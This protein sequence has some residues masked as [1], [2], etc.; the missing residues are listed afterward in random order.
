[1]NGRKERR[2]RRTNI[3]SKINASDSWGMGINGMRTRRRRKKLVKYH[4]KTFGTLIIITN[5]KENFSK[6]FLLLLNKKSKMLLLCPLSHG[7]SFLPSF[8]V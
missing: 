7:L 4:H 2:K 5:T 3:R 1:M 6:S 8:F